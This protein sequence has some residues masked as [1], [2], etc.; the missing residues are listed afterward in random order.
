MPH[1]ENPPIGLEDTII[2][3]PP[4]TLLLALQSV[5]RVRLPDRFPVSHSLLRGL[6][7]L[8][9]L[10]IPSNILV[11]IGTT[12]PITVLPGVHRESSMRLSDSVLLLIVWMCTIKT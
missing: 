4:T 6:V 5:R 9:C 10:V 12:M 2:N 7:R 1:Y 11:V 8:L 3:L